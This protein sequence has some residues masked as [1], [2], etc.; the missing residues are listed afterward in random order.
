[1]TAEEFFKELKKLIDATPNYP[2]H[3]ENC[4]NSEYADHVYYCK[5]LTYSFDCLKCTDGIYLYDSVNSTNCVDCDYAGESELCYDSVDAKK[6]FNS[7]HLEDCANLTDCSFCVRCANNHDM[8]GC[9]GLRN[10]SFCIF[11][12]QLTEDEY[13]EKLKIYKTWPQEK[14]LKI[15]NEIRSTLPVT[16]THESNNE[17][18]PYGDYVYYNKNCY[19]CFDAVSNKDSGYLYDTSQHTTS[20]DVTYST[21]NELC[22]QVTDSGYC[23]NC[24]YV[25]YSANCQDSSYVINGLDVKNCL[26]SVNRAHAEYEIL[27]RK[28]SQEEYEKLSKEILSDINKKNLGWADLRFH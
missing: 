16:Q 24:D 3:Q 22:Y 18:S 7:Q 5:N 10:K 9:V 12:R 25:V 2:V 15:V 19:M 23:F 1:M 27:N 14:V 17:N 21:D 13:R 11:N 8:F 4:E 6:C 28:Y 20:Y 26:G